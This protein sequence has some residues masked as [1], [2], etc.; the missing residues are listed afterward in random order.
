MALEKSLDK[1][2]KKA[3]KGNMAAHGIS[4]LWKDVR[5][6]SDRAEDALS[7]AE[8]MRRLDAILRDMSAERTSEPDEH[9][10]KSLRGPVGLAVALIKLEELLTPDES[11]KRQ[12]ISS[13]RHHLNSDWKEIRDDISASVTD[14][15]T[16]AWGR[17]TPR[18]P[19]SDRDRIRQP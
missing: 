1:R 16:V 18:G 3:L 13:L 2:Q 14:A 10:P 12:I 7:P 11:K 19:G 8:T 5:S 6:E 15:L 4:Y 9:R 17:R